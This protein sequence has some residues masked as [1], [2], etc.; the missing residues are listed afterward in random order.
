MTGLSDNVLQAARKAAQFGVLILSSSLVFASDFH[1]PSRYFSYHSRMDVQGPWAPN[2]LRTCAAAQNNGKLNAPQAIRIV[3]LSGADVVLECDPGNMADTQA[4]IKAAVEQ[5]VAAEQDAAAVSRRALDEGIPT[6]STDAMLM[7]LLK[8]D[9]SSFNDQA[10]IASTQ[11]EVKR[12]QYIDRRDAASGQKTTANWV[13]PPESLRERNPAVAAEELFPKFKAEALKRAQ[14]VPGTFVMRSLV[15]NVRYDLSSGV[16][17]FGNAKTADTPITFKRPMNASFR[18]IPIYALNANDGVAKYTDGMPLTVMGFRTIVGSERRPGVVTDR[19]LVAYPIKMA[20]DQA[21]Q[22]LNKSNMLIVNTVM[23]ITGSERSQG[24]KGLA[25]SETNGSVIARV[26]RVFVTDV[27]GHVLAA[28][29][30]SALPPWQP[31][32]AGRPKAK[33]R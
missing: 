24:Q 28:Y 5:L 29:E 3:A 33:A 6:F 12:A 4:R 32:Q 14:G 15:G 19:E 31:K 30:A 26:D 18:G 9:A 27:T 17:L 13:F 25:L 7:S 10:W 11:E 22:F 20:Q 1:D 21:E 8:Y 16:L 23:T 2:A